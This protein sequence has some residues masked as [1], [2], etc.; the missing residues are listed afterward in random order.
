MTTLVFASKNQ[1]K[2]KEINEI[3]SHDFP[4]S[5]IVIKGL[6]DISFNE[7]I[8]ETSPTIKENAIQ[9]ARYIYDRYEIDCF[10]EDSGLEVD[11][12]NGDPGVYSARYAG[13]QRNDNDNIDLLLNKMKYAKDRTARFKTTIALYYCD[14]LYIFEGICQGRISKRRL[15]SQGFGYDPVFIPDGEERSFGQM[16]SEDKN[17]ISHRYIALNK[18]I[19]VLREISNK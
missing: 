4:Q 11:F 3:L 13:T 17:K 15:G 1:N 10:A 9:K 14:Q 16:P 7:D 5:N 8:P 6:D 12:L 19:A 2:I 18:M